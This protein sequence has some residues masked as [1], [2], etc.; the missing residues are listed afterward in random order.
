METN[1]FDVKYYLI[2]RLIE[3]R[4]N[5]VS[6]TSALCETAHEKLLKKHEGGVE[7]KTNILCLMLQD[8]E[9]VEQQS[10]ESKDLFEWPPVW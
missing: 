4:E 10:L 6:L 3:C 1:Y 2:F 7:I 5:D 9:A 8:C